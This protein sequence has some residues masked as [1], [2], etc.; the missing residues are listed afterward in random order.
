MAL[1]GSM[2]LRSGPGE[3]QED[4]EVAVLLDAQFGTG[5]RECVNN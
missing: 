3:V 5:A 1:A 2:V 4:P